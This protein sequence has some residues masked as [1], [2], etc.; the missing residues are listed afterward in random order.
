MPSDPHDPL[1]QRREALTE[2]ERSL[3]PMPE[4]RWWLW[5]ALAL[6]LVFVALRGAEWLLAQQQGVQPAISSTAVRLPSVPSPA[7]AGALPPSPAK[8]SRSL[9]SYGVTKCTSAAGKAEY[10]DGSCPAGSRA[11]TVWVQ[12]D[13]NLADGMSAAE[14]EA[15]MRSNSAVAA[16]TQQHERRVAQNTGDALDE[17]AALNARIK[18][19]DAVARQPQS[20]RTQDELARERRAAQDRQFRLRCP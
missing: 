3:R 9:E 14:R 7:D 5:V 4:R 20:T 18:W 17:C 8:L 16:Q 15:S 11:T 10:S 6:L 13:V 19:I 1:H 2:W 12:P